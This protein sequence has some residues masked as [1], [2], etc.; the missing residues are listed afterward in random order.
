MD[1]ERQEKKYEEPKCTSHT[2]RATQARKHTDTRAPGMKLVSLWGHPRRASALY[3][4]SIFFLFRCTLHLDRFDVMNFILLPLL[5]V[6]SLLVSLLFGFVLLQLVPCTSRHLVHTYAGSTF[7]H[8]Y[9]RL[10]LYWSLR[11]LSVRSSVSSILIA[12]CVRYFVRAYYAFRR[13]LFGLC[14]I[15]N[16]LYEEGQ[17]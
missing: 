10:V 7:M 5:F 8:Q 2:T 1:T 3:F 9:I 13:N 4:S 15:S 16:S 14:P 11:Q 12:S 6:R 17:T